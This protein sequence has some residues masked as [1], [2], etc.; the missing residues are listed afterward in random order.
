MQYW[1]EG[2]ATFTQLVRPAGW[3]GLPEKSWQV[4]CVPAGEP[5][6]NAIPRNVF[7]NSRDDAA[8]GVKDRKY[9]ICGK[10]CPWDKGFEHSAEAEIVTYGEKLYTENAGFYP[11]T[12]YPPFTKQNKKRIFEIFSVT[13]R[14]WNT[15]WD[16]K[17]C[18]AWCDGGTGLD[19]SIKPL[20]L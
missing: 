1:A 16:Y 17:D 8:K 15:R 12:M 2:K 18:R 19:W 4:L 10:L 3:T 9:F 6:S 5:V 13:T 14:T 20:L 7:L 11:P